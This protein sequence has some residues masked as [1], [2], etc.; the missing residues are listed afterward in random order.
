[1]TIISQNLQGLND[2]VK[3]DVVRNYFRPL[4]P[5]L[6]IVCFQEHKLRGDP[7]LGLKNAIWPRATFFA[8]EA[9]LGYRHTLG[10]PRAGKGG[11]C[12]WIS[13]AISHL[14]SITGHSKCKRA[15]WVRFS[16]LPGGD[17]NVINI[18]ASTE[19]PE[20]I[21]LWEELFSILPRDCRSVMLGDFNFVE[22]RADKSNFCG[23]LVTDGERI[24][25][26]QLTSALG[27]E[28]KFQST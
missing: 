19:A 17:I 4:L 12:M 8:Q 11:V 21:E 27:V 5:S 10:Q 22:N 23:K 18:Y 16:G 3:V 7:L 2:P 15:Q 24:V 26:H 28:D 6:D 14:I 9:A 20:R 25:F 13:E 1:M